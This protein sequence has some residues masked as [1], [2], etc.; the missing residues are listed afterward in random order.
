M[1]D[2]ILRALK[3]CGRI[4]FWLS[5][6]INWL[7]IAWCLGA[8]WYPHWI[9]ENP[10]VKGMVTG[11]YLLVA[12][13]LQVFCLR[14]RWFIFASVLLSCCVC[15]CWHTLLHPSGQ[16]DWDPPFQ[17]M[18]KAHF[19]ADGKSVTIENI[20]DFHYR[21]EKDYDIR[22]RTETYN[23]DDLVSMDYSITH[24]CGNETF[25][26]IMLSFGFKD[27]RY[28]VLSPE[29]RMEREK[30]YEILPGFFRRYELIF[31]LAT[32]EDAFQLRTNHRKYEQEEVL[33]YPTNTPREIMVFLLTDLLKRANELIEHPE[34][35]NGVTYN[36]LSSMAPT[37]EKLSFN[38]CSTWRGTFNGITDRIGYR[39]GW[40]KR[41]RA[42][43]SFP[44]FRK[45]HSVN[46]FVEDLVNPPDY[47]QRIRNF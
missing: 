23:F 26:H 36:C 22:Y 1:K 10:A 31:I 35:Y 3:C 28:L 8:I 46:R 42:D 33:L 47:S 43:E 24:W 41:L 6:S 21:S 15:V 38:F 40:L 4:G 18:P 5:W 45:S 19:S 27:G 9:S 25:G 34:F 11:G 17:R 29:A 39:T 14:K 30:T 44:E 7:L 20:R 16:L 37:A 32:E 12:L 2:K 13:A